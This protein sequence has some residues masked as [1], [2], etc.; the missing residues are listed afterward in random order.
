MRKAVQ[1]NKISKEVKGLFFKGGRGGRMLS[2]H[3]DWQFFSSTPVVN[4]QMLDFLPSEAQEDTHEEQYVESEDKQDDNVDDFTYQLVNLKNMNE[5]AA[6][7]LRCKCNIDQSIGSF[8]NYCAGTHGI[9]KQK[10]LAIAQEWRI[11]E[12]NNNKQEGSVEIRNKASV[13]FASN[14]SFFCKECCEETNTTEQ[15]TI[16]KGKNYV[17]HHTNRPNSSWYRENVELV[18]ATLASGLGASEVSDFLTFLNVPKMHSFLNNQF[19]SIEKLIGKHIRKIAD[20]SMQEML[21]D[22]VTKTLESKNIN[23]DEFKRDKN[24]TV[25]LTV[26]YDMGWNKR[27]SGHRYDSICLVI[28]FI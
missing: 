11:S 12:R 18:L 4:P 20:K 9:E 26:S 21:D 16:F 24:S 6:S 2:S 8:I 5:A 23:V 3:S 1:K 10:L 22:E 17:G 28:A 13:G 19:F 27:S 15:N 14:T 7:K 25:G